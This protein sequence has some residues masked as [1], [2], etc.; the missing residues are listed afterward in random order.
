M[1][2]YE[3]LKAAIAAI[4]RENGNNEITGNLLQ[5]TLLSMVDSVGANAMF[6]GIATPE[7]IPGNPEQNVFY[8]ATQ[9][10]IYFN[11]NAITVED[12]EVV[13]FANKTGE[14]VKTVTGFASQSLIEQ[15]LQEWQEIKDANFKVEVQPHIERIDMQDLTA[16]TIEPDKYYI[17]GEV[18][19]LAIGLAAA[20][21]GTIGNYTFQFTSPAY[22]PTILSLPIDVKFPKESGSV[23]KIVENTTYQISILNNLAIATSWGV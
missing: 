3:T 9:P 18:A 17:F 21:E 4:I 10:G 5:Q 16:A 22:A 15:I 13:I 11:F 20:K 6:A 12:G 7:T 1:G 14:W 8:I 23:L 2:T 19:S